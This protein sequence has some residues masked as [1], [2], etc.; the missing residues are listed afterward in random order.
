MMDAIHNAIGGR[1]FKSESRRIAP[2]FNPATGEQVA[3]LPLSTTDE[4][5]AAVVAAKDAAPGW[6]ATPPTAAGRWPPSSRTC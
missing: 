1:K 5:N 4:V 2:V 6:G 3:A